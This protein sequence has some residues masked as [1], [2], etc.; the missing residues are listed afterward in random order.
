MQGGIFHRSDNMQTEY[1]RL[2]T[3]LEQILYDILQ[4]LKKSNE[5]PTP[6]KRKTTKKEVKNDG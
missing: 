1:G 5:K 3:A 2:G 6:A 4:E